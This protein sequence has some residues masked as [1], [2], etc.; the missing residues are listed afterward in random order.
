MMKLI[1]DSGS[2]KTDWA[3]TD[4][5]GLQCIVHTQGLNPVHQPREVMVEVLKTELLPQLD[6]VEVHEVF[7]YGSG[8]RPTEESLMCQLLQECTG[9]QYVEAHSDLL[10]AARA[11]CGHEEG[12]AC[13]LGTGAN[14]CL[15]DGKQI[16][17]NTPALGY[18][19]GDEGSG[20]NLGISLLN[21]LYKGVLPASL[22]RQFEDE[23]GLQ[24]SD[25]IERV[26]RQPLANRF[27][28]SL[29]PFIHTHLHEPLLSRMVVERFRVFLCRNISPYGR[30]DLPIAAVGSIAFYFQDQLRLAAEKEGYTIGRVERSPLEA[31][32]KYHA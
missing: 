14:S 11:L 25:V 5:N 12:V 32:L 26:Y 19:L 2:T 1:A 9:A 4:E 23:T 8:V 15:F 24:L 21:G 30:H 28:A 3:L 6:G 16:V 31:L 13:I 17:R 29:S 18:I 7:F 20:A 27:L 10:G 22:R